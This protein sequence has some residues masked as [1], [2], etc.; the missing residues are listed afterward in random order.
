MK[1]YMD[2][3]AEAKLKYLQEAND[4]FS[5]FRNK[6]TDKIRQKLKRSGF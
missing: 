2:L 5:K 6:K 4:F 1:I 3:P